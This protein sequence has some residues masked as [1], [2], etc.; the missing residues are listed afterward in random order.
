M[1]A[2]ASKPILDE[3]FA[4]VSSAF[5]SLLKLVRVPVPL[6][7]AVC[8]AVMLGTATVKVQSFELPRVLG[9]LASV[10]VLIAVYLGA[11]RAALILLRLL[12]EGVVSADREQLL[13]VC[14]RIRSESS[15][16]NPWSSTRVSRFSKSSLTD[17]V[18]LVAIHVPMVVVLATSFWVLSEFR[19]KAPD[20]MVAIERSQAAV[21]DMKAADKS[22][23]R[24]EAA[25]RVL[26]AL[27]EEKK[28]MREIFYMNVYY[29]AAGVFVLLYL[30]FLYRIGEVI[31]LVNRDDAA[32]RL[33]I[34]GC[35]FALMALPFS[36]MDWVWM[37]RYL[38]LLL[39][40]L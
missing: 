23:A 3:S 34:L 8:V 22:T 40:T 27:D 16:Q 33:L 18:G 17:Y 15:L 9:A 4:G 32:K 13:A 19:E 36:I 1:C 26:A 6:A 24:R 39:K 21:A 10:I 12:Q 11:Y 38:R 30:F 31:W 14:L 7:S 37:I 5:Q 20:A 2:Q 28:A 35:S 29:T 25:L